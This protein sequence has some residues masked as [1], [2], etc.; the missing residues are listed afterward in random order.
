MIPDND[1]RVD[2]FRP[3]GVRVLHI[4]SGVVVIV[5]DDEEPSFHQARLNAVAEIERR[6][7]KP[8]APGTLNVVGVTPAR[9]HAMVDEVEHR[10]PGAILVKNLVGNLNVVVDG[11]AVG[12]CDL[13]F[14]GVQLARV[15]DDLCVGEVDPGHPDRLDPV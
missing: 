13:R 7:R 4:P 14:G 6:L 15:D 12:W 2:I 3:G 11:H 5:R 10:W 1:L 9:L 8:A